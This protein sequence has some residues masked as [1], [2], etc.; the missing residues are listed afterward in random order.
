MGAVDHFN[1]P[2]APRANSLRPAVNTFVQDGAGRVLLVH[3]AEQDLHTLPGG[4]Q[5]P[6]ETPLDA[7]LR[8]TYAETGVRVAVT[9]LVGVY[10]DP[11]HVVAHDDGEVRQEFV[12]C[13]RATPSDGELDTRDQTMKADWV[14]PARMYELA[15]HPAVRL[16]IQHGFDD[17]REPYWG[18]D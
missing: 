13:F 12:L 16:R 8:T 14:N 6:G 3:R 17:R 11:A 15:I 9:G 18:Q 1:D 10:S 5:R 4:E 7:V 2:D